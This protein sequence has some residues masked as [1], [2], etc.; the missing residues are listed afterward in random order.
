MYDISDRK[1]GSRD[2][3]RDTLQRLGFLKLQES[4]YLFP[5]PCGDEI[6][7]LRT[8]YRLDSDVTMLVTSKI[9]YD[10]AY[11]QYFGIR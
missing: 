11:R 10:E 4:V 8:Y 5:Y 3:L 1:K 6:E 7:F 2:V 9:E